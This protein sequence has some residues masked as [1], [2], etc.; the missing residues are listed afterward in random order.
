MNILTP[1]DPLFDAWRMISPGELEKGPAALYNPW[2]AALPCP[3][4]H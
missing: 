1:L 4:A 3:F 2:Y